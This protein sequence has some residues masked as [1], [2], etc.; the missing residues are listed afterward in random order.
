MHDRTTYPK[1]YAQVNTDICTK[2]DL[3][4]SRFDFLGN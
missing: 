3:Y 2:F 1:R 4:G